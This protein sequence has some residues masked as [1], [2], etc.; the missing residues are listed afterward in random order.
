[1]HN[2][3]F[4]CKCLHHIAPD[5]FKS[6]LIKSSHVYSIRRNGLDILIP[7][8]RV[9]SAKKGTFYTRAKALQNLPLHLNEV[10]S[11]VIFKTRLNDVLFLKIFWIC[12]IDLFM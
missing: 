12:L 5:L 3:T 8:V 2:W 6:Y 11:R 4:V 9:E 1:M 7:E 10:D